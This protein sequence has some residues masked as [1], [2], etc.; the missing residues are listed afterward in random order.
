MSALVNP[1]FVRTMA[2]YNAE[3]NRSLYE[4]S[5]RIPDSERRKDRGAFWG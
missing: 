1:G 4:V 2:A 5:A 3:M